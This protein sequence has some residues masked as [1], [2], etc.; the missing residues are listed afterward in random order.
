MVLSHM[1]AQIAALFGLV[2]TIWTLMGGLLV[3]TFIVL[4][5]TQ[6]RLPT[7]FLA[8]MSAWEQFFRILF[9]IVDGRCLGDRALRGRRFAH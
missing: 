7:V 2:R 4:M 6:R 3:T 5:P 9:R 1:N 8:A